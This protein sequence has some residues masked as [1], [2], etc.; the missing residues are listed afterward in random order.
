MVLGTALK[1]RGVSGQCNCSR[2]LIL[3]LFHGRCLWFSWHYKCVYSV[4]E[5]AEDFE[6]SLI[7]RSTSG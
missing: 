1:G 2:S 7:F 5:S 6:T 4:N 3:A